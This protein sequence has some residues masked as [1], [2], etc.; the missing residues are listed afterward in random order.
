MRKKLPGIASATK[1]L[2]NGTHRTYYYAWRGGPLLK[3]EDGTPLKPED[4]RFFVAYTDAHR[5]RKMPATGTMF[6][7][8]ALFRSSADFRGLFCLGVNFFILPGHE[9]TGTLFP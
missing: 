2:A 3:A 4:P 7:L 9:A 8:V 5:A 1:K 6:N